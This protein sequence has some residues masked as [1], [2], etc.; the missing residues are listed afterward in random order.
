MLPVPLPKRR[1]LKFAAVYFVDVSLKF[2]RITGIFAVPVDGTALSG[3]PGAFETFRLRIL[4]LL[5]LSV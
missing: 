1:V 2:M 3:T 4:I 5:F